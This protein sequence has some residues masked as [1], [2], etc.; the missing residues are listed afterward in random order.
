MSTSNMS[1]PWLN[2]CGRLR[3]LPYEAAPPSTCASLGRSVLRRRSVSDHFD[4]RLHQGPLSHHDRIFSSLFVRVSSRR[5]DSRRTAAGPA[6]SGLADLALLA[7]T[8]AGQS[9]SRS[10]CPLATPCDGGV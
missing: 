3:R 7:A 6:H 1:A 4:E 10:A 5:P 8:A 9:H 2:W